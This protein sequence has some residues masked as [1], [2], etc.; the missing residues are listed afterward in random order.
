MLLSPKEH[1]M[2]HRGQLMMMERMVVP[3]HLT[4]VLAQWAQAQQARQAQQ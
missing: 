3:V 2:H 4:Q 1:E